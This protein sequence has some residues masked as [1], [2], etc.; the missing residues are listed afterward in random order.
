MGIMAHLVDRAVYDGDIVFQQNI[1]VATTDRTSTF[2]EQ[3][4]NGCI[5]ISRKILYCITQS[6]PLRN[7]Q[8]A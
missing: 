2:I 7:V 6:L 1:S 3:V 4:E 8:Q 5:E